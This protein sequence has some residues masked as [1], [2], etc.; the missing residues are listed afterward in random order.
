MSVSHEIPRL[1]TSSSRHSRYT[2]DTS[3][4]A[5]QNALNILREFDVVVGLCYFRLTPLLMRPESS[6]I[7]L[8]ATC[9]F[10]SGLGPMKEADLPLTFSAA[11]DAVRIRGGKAG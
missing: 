9:R 5:V 11:R 10:I 3:L 8:W 4:C 7:G 6:C 1:G 2:I